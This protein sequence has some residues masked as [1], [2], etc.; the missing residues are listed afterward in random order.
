MKCLAFKKSREVVVSEMD[1]T[2]ALA[3]LNSLPHTVTKT[4]PSN[5]RV[6]QVKEWLLESLPENLKVGDS[7]NFGTGLW[8]HAV[9]LGHEFANYNCR[10][11]KTQIVISIRSVHTDLDNLIGLKLK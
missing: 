2:A 6:N 1:L 9:P 8:A 7:I 4:M 3:H 5:W 11:Q 10:E